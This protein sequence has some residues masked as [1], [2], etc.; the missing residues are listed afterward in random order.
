MLYVHFSLKTLLDRCGWHLS[1]QRL[2]NCPKVVH[3]ENGRDWCCQ[4]PWMPETL[5]VAPRIVLW[6]PG[7]AWA[8]GGLVGSPGNSDLALEGGWGSTGALGLAFGICLL[9]SVLLV[10]GSS[11]IGTRSGRCG[12]CRER[13]SLYLL[14]LLSLP[15]SL[16]PSRPSF[17]PSSHYV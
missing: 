17:L 10:E 7:C 16:S 1:L 4:V 9:S 11:Q 5:V 2:V 8:V 14:L 6:C 13:A 3:P 12:Q 15:P